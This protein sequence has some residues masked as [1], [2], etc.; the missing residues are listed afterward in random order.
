MYTTWLS[1]CTEKCLYPLVSRSVY[2]HKLNKPM[3]LVPWKPAP[4]SPSQAPFGSLPHQGVTVILT[5]AFKII[6]CFSAQWYILEIFPAAHRPWLGPHQWVLA[7]VWAHNIPTIKRCQHHLHH[8][9][10]CDMDSFLWIKY[11][12]LP[13]FT[14]F[15]LTLF[16]FVS[17]SFFLFGHPVAY[18]VTRP[19]IR[20]EPQLWPMLQV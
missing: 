5:S 6:L 18:G 7:F 13:F 20:S 2:L 1:I 16:L 15:P 11:P 4:W 19:G 9:V 3:W 10:L 12:R 17:F 14:S 8:I